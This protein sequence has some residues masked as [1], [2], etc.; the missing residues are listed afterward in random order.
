MASCFAF[1]E[2]AIS[3]FSA[4]PEKVRLS[5]VVRFR[6]ADAFLASSVYTLMTPAMLNVAEAARRVE[7]F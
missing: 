1:P 5:M 6:L 4:F 7:I 2:K 3:L